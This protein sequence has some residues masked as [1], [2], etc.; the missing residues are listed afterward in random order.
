MVCQYL[1]SK[2][3][4]KVFRGFLPFFSSGRGA[5]CRALEWAVMG[6]CLGWYVYPCL[7]VAWLVGLLRALQGHTVQRY[8]VQQYR[9]GKEEKEEGRRE[10]EETS[11]GKGEGVG[12]GTGGARAGRV[13]GCISFVYCE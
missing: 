4:K 1:F 12:K 5:A 9:E 13:Q 6:L 8:R 10:E 11:N 3:L 2:N 7:G